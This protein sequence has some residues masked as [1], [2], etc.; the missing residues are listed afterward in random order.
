MADRE[1]RLEHRP[2]RIKAEVLPYDNCNIEKLL[3]QLSDK[4]FIFIYSVSD[5]KYIQ[6]LKFGLHQNPH[7]K[8]AESTIQA[9]EIPVQAPDK[10]GSRPA[11]SL[12]LIPDSLNPTPDACARAREVAEKPYGKILDDLNQK[13]GT[14]YR[15][16]SQETRRLIDAR[17]NAGFTVD[18]FFTVHTKKV[19]DWLHDPDRCQFLRPQTLYGTKFEAYLNQKDPQTSVSQTTVRNLQA[20]QNVLARRAAERE[21]ANAQ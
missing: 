19:R 14:A 1:G 5:C 9:P 7:C 16:S 4:N 2:K 20:A 10:N 13:A 15:H 6:I 12:N 17:L 11:D 8:E 21:A 3:R 18:D